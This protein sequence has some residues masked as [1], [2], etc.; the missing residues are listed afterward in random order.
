L[1]ACLYI[2]VCLWVCMCVYMCVCIF[3]FVLPYFIHMQQYRCLLLLHLL[4]WGGAWSSKTSSAETTGETWRSIP[5]IAHLQHPTT[6]VVRTGRAC[7]RV[8]VCVCVRVCVCLCVCVCACV[9]VCACVLLDC[10]VFPV[11]FYLSRIVFVP[12]AV[13]NVMC[14]SLPDATCARPSLERF[15]YGLPK[16]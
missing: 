4:R 8:C 14:K 5:T 3:V 11:L 10:L 2:S 6:V 15:T 13:W 1:L 9:Y 12:R 7:V 16:V